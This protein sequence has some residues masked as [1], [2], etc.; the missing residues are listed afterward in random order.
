MINSLRGIPDFLI[1]SWTWSE[2]WT[3]HEVKGNP[4]WP[5]LQLEMVV[6]TILSF[7][8][9]LKVT[10]LNAKRARAR[11]GERLLGSV[12]RGCARG[13]TCVRNSDSGH[14]PHCCP[15]PSL[16][17]WM[18][19]ICIVLPPPAAYA[20]VVYCICICVPRR[21]LY[22]RSEQHCLWLRNGRGTRK[23]KT[24]KS[25]QRKKKVEIRFL[26]AIV[27][28]NNLG[29]FWSTK[30]V[31]QANTNSI[32]TLCLKIFY[33]KRLNPLIPTP[34]FEPNFVV[35][36][37]DTLKSPIRALPCQSVS[38]WICQSYYR[39]FSKLFVKIDLWILW[40]LL[41]HP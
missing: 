21:V 6:C 31:L 32:E 3:L 5:L 35:A 9:F 10:W 25:D 12:G 33:N 17:S 38:H 18:Q 22:L 39:D 19:H 24:G 41:Q 26:I 29:P 16:G 2:T 30:N 40:F 1:L 14:A 8:C 4:A 23:G 27:S 13:A 34:I 11:P 36:G 37:T 28:F 20:P 15:T 7:P